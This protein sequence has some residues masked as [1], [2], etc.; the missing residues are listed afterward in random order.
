MSKF[1]SLFINT[2]AILI[3]AY[4]LP[5]VK[6]ES[7][8]TAIVV[9]VVLGLLNTFI[10]PILI[11]LTLPVTIITLGFFTLI[12]N[13]FLIILTSSLVPGFYLN[14]FWSAFI[15]SLLLWIVNSFLRSMAK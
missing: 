5:G 11:I 2:L 15:F 4:L 3:T 9:A 8:L 10:K 7:F 14:S 12:I 13:T 1:I 6:V